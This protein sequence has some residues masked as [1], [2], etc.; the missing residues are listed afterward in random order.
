MVRC[1]DANHYVGDIKL[2]YFRCFFYAM[3]LLLQKI[4]FK[5]FRIDSIYL[6]AETGQLPER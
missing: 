4:E 1:I 5:Y 3:A 2:S 6:F